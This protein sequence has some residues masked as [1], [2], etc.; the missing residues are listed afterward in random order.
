MANDICK[1]MQDAFTDIIIKNFPIK[2]TAKRIGKAERNMDKG[3]DAKDVIPENNIKKNQRLS[4]EYI[5]LSFQ[6]FFY[7]SCG[8]L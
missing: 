2:G 3:F 4:K 1:S 6:G 7:C 8:F 5:L